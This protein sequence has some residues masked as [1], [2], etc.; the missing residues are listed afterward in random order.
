MGTSSGTSWRRLVRQS[1]SLTL[2]GVTP[3]PALHTSLR[4]PGSPTSPENRAPEINRLYYE[5]SLV[6][7]LP[8]CAVMGVVNAGSGENREIPDSESLNLG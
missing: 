8:T 2:H 5:G 4:G 7:S 1:G 3:V 6:L